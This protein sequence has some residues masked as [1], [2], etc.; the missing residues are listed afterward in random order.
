LDVNARVA[1]PALSSGLEWINT[2]EPPTLEAMRGRVTLLHFWTFDCVNCI[3]VL[4]D[5]RFLENKYHDGLS[6]I[7]IHTPKFEYQRA[8][9]PV[10]KAVNRNYIRHPVASDPG[11]AMWQAYGVQA[12]PTMALI[13]AQG[14]LAAVLP[15]EGRRNEADMMIGHLLEEA[16]KQDLRVYESQVSTVRP[17]PRQ[18]L[19]F[20]TRLL[21]TDSSLWIADT[22]HNRI[23]ECNL[24]GRILRQFGSGNPGFWDGANLDSGFA[25]P[26]GMTIAKE[27]LFVADTGNH[28]IRRIRLQ[29]GEVKTIAGTGAVGH[30]IPHEYVEP[31]KIGMSAPNDVV[32]VGENLYIAVTGQNQ[33]WQLNLNTNKL[34]A[35]AGSGKLGIDDGAGVAASFAEPVSLSTIGQQL[36]IVDAAASAIRTLRLLE[37]KVTTLLGSGLYEFGD[38]PG[39]PDVARLQHPLAACVDAR[40]LVFI[41]DSYNGKIKALNLRT[42]E[43]RTLNL[44]YHLHEPAGIALGANALWISNTN[45]HEVVRVDLGTG[46]IKRL[47]IA[48]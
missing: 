12:W 4:P 42:T 31:T 22:G 6:V 39:K 46:Q 23:L 29:D 2:D 16:A 43:T 28:A 11:Y 18:P 3:N 34:I 40:G 19:R 33:I 48:E 15:G 14:Q 1:A 45:A 5:L 25:A 20:P 47:T 30:D 36:I 26:Q 44:P 35:L 32:A 17:E 41:A 27:A 21:A 37:N 8:P 24:E 7:G 9:G 38:A 13:D 10:L